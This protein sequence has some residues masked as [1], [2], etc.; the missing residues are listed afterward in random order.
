MISLVRLKLRQKLKQP[1]KM[2][3]CIWK[4]LEEIDY[5]SRDAWLNS[6]W[7]VRGI[8]LTLQRQ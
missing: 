4:L 8:K 1:V 2:E 5:K 6:D 7:L 3:K